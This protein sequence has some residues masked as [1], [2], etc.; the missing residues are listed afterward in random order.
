MTEMVYRRTRADDWMP[1]E[2]IG[3]H[4]DGRLVLR[5]VGRRYPGVLLADV[6]QIRL[7]VEG[8]PLTMTEHAMLETVQ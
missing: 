8:V 2:V 7:V 3:Q 4:A 1:V 5:E 6:S